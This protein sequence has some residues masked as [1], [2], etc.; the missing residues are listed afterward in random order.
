MTACR[1]GISLLARVQLN[2]SLVFSA[3]TREIS[4]WTHA[5]REIPYLNAP[6]YYSNFH[7]Q[8]SCPELFWNNLRAYSSI[9]IPIC[10][11]SCKSISARRCLFFVEYQFECRGKSTKKSRFYLRS[12]LRQRHS[13]LF[14]TAGR[15]CITVMNVYFM[16]W[17]LLLLLLF[18][19]R[20][21]PFCCERVRGAKEYWRATANQQNMHRCL[22]VLSKLIRFLFL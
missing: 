18:L 13:I 6:M 19:L 9:L 3:L 20:P 5:R 22:W 16:F 14:L 12:V 21:Q 4:S 2:I 17:S 8:F 11:M 7:F 15:E 1:Y 10:S